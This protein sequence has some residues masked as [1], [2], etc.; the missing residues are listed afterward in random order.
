MTS[1]VR[2]RLVDASFCYEPQSSYQGDDTNVSPV[3]NHRH[4][5]ANDL[6]LSRALVVV[7]SSLISVRQR[8]P[9]HQRCRQF[10]TPL[11]KS[12][13]FPRLNQKL[14]LLRSSR[15]PQNAPR[16]IIP[17]SH[18]LTPKRVASVSVV[19]VSVQVVLHP[20]GHL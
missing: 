18:A 3:I 11:G 5:I 19:E 1:L 14:L 2:Y 20:F 12:H 10:S 6:A 9:Y 7:A 4:L 15:R 17:R 8:S 13:S 16:K